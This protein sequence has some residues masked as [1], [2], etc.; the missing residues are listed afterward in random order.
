LIDGFEIGRARL[1]A[2]ADHQ[3]PPVGKAPEIRARG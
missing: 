3:R 2:A 1:R